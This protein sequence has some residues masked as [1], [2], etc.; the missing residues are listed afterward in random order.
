[1]A[2][3][4][5]EGRAGEGLA[6][7]GWHVEQ[8]AERSRF[9]GR[10]GGGAGGGGR[11]VRFF[12]RLSGHVPFGLV[13]VV[14]FAF[15]GGAGDDKRVCLRGLAFTAGGMGDGGLYIGAGRGWAVWDMLYGDHGLRHGF[16]P[17]GG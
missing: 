13:A 17:T 5:A 1:M 14:F 3:G 11:W 9:L 6:L 4:L 10:G 2:L 8:I 15:R 7:G 12:F 16:G